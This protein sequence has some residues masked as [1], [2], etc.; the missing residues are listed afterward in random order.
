MLGAFL[1]Q[2]ES[3]FQAFWYFGM[4][5]GGVAVL[6]GAGSW[7]TVSAVAPLWR[8][9]GRHI[10]VLLVSVTAVSILLFGG[11]GVAALI[12]LAHNPAAG[13]GSH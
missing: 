8:G 9:E 3:D 1:P 6:V 2:R 7:L 10:A 13:P 4:I 12:G 5:L 11:M